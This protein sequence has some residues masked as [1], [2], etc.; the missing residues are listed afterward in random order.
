MK[1]KIMKRFRVEVTAVPKVEAVPVAREEPSV[2][3]IT[4]SLESIDQPNHRMV[5]SKASQ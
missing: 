1:V 4:S 3:A 2:P 5:N